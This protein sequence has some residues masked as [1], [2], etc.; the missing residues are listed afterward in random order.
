V[1]DEHQVREAVEGG[2][3]AFG[4]LHVLYNNA[5]VLWHD[6][7]VGVLGVLDGLLPT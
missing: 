1:A 2:V 5:G 7:D 6:R 4:A 3:E